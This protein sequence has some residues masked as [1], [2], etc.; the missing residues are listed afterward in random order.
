VNQVRDVPEPTDG[1]QA[2][3][4]KQAGRERYRYAEQFPYY[5]PLDPEYLEDVI[6]RVFGPV[7]HHY[8]RPRILGRHRLPSGG[9]AILAANH[10]GNS[11]PYDGMVLDALLW[12][13][14]SFRRGAKIR[15]VFEKELTTTWWMRPF[16]IDNF[17][18]RGG[19][20]DM[21]FDNF[22]R[23]LES[24]ERVLYFP[25][26]VPGIGKGF[27]R[28]YR[29]Q[30]FSSSFVILAARHRAPVYP[31][32]II[33]AEWTIPFCFTLP[34]LDRLAERFLRVP[35]IPLPAAPLGLLFPFLWY[36]ALPVRMVFVIG[37]PIDV[38]ALVAEAGEED[39]ERPNRE[40]MRRVADQVKATMQE[41]LDQNVQRYGNRP[42]GWRSLRRHLTANWRALLSLL[43]T[44]WPIRFVR[45]DRN[46]R[47]PPA[48]NR[49]HAL[50][51]DLDLVAFYL[52][53]GWPILAL[54]RRFRKPPYG[55]RGLSA[56]ERRERE[57]AFHWHL[58]ERPL[59]PREG[60]ATEGATK[61]GAAAG[62][63]P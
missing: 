8:F 63:L 28:R 55:Y 1:K 14:E 16:G 50:V 20:V 59:P 25:E 60:A 30:R 23:L 10:S 40:T 4:G 43:P 41:E 48:R 44:G 38:A 15:A 51:R 56:K 45:H 61:D 39:L 24:G 17:W 31:V 13:K 19:G 32:H 53:F 34:W 27:F 35:F 49:L 54:C 47:R 21:T 22:H 46:R 33:N 42:Y 18:R 7:S 6:E 52:P 37:E 62:S 58:K 9:P 5:D 36:L 12:K 57:G 29:L 3:E 2:K 26:G 11:F